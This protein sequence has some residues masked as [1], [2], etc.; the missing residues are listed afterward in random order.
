MWHPYAFS[1]YPLL[2]TNQVAAFYPPN[3][4]F[5]LLPPVLANNAVV[6]SSFAVAGL[7]VFVLARRLCRDDAG[8]AV[9]G[10]AFG[11]SPF[12]FAHLTHQSLIASIAWLPWVLYGFELVR[13]RLTPPRLL[14]GAGALALTLLAGHGQMF[15]FVVLVVALYA[16]ALRSIR[17]MV[18]AVLLIAVGTAL[19]AV[20]LVPTTSI[21]VDTDRA[22]V[23]YETAVS[24]SFP[25]SHTALLGF[26]YLFGN[27][28]PQGPYTDAY[29]GEWNLPEMTGYP[30]MVVLTLAAAGLGALRRDRRVA[31]LV[32]V[33]TVSFVMALGPTTPMAHFV[34]ALPVLGQF[35]S[36]GR[37]IVGP[38]LVVTLLAAFGVA[39]LRAP[40]TRRAAAVA[41]VAAAMAVVV[42]AF[43]VP[44]LGAVHA[45]VAHGDTRT[46]ALVIPVLMAVAGAALCVLTLRVPRSAVVLLVLTVAVDAVVAFGMWSGWRSGSPS[47]EA[48]RADRSLAVP[49]TFGPMNDVPGGIERYL[50]VGQRL[51]TPEDPDVTDLKRVR[52]ANGFDPLAPR[53]YLDA[54]SM[55][56]L[57]RVAGNTIVLQPGNHVLDLLRVSV[58]LVDRNVDGP[59]PPPRPQALPA[60]FGPSRVVRGGRNLRYDY[61]PRLPDAFVVGAAQRVTR[62]EAQRR[63]AG[64]IAFEPSVTVLVEA[65]CRACFRARSPGRAGS[66]AATR[67]GSS[68][69]DL[70][71]N[72]V[73]DAM[74][75]VSQAWFPGW[76]ATVDGRAARVV[77]VD[78]LVQGVPVGPGHHRVNLRYRAP[79]LTRGAALSLVTLAGLLGW[80]ARERRSR[81]AAG[82]SA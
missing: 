70:D 69:V 80:W 42:A 8:A 3:W 14:L 60:S 10:V 35:R 18:V 58:V 28:R 15:A 72:V 33:G 34:H 79:G 76:T 71:V 48:F 63:I 6:V 45:H 75:V 66:V 19:A 26:P 30:G 12:L 51:G 39:R 46:Y 22:H 40:A 64:E 68:S 41:S 54:L 53:R 17:A 73:R 11:L 62:R 49:T 56:Y 81:R 20:Q 21:I 77:R 32:F 82:A 38:D 23:D 2:A 1:G 61:R 37:Y 27:T 59:G 25:G 55:D 47:L 50:S 31:A 78:G 67:W 24:Y 9:A 29:R 4:S 7:G 74:L 44:N 52:S 57:G 43:V 65:D 16:V 5:L 36:W 13:E